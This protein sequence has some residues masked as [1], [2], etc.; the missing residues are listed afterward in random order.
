MAVIPKKF[1][2][3]SSLP[4]KKL[5][6]KIK[7]GT[8]EYTPSA[9]ILSVSRFMRM[10]KTETVYYGSCT[11]EKIQLFYHMAKKR[12]G[13][14]TGFYGKIVEDGKGSRLE[15]C[16]RKPVYAYVI[17]LLFLLVC[18]LCALGTYAAGSQQGAVVFL[19]VGLVGTVVM[20]WD[21]H[22]VFLRNYLSTFSDE[23]D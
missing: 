13:S 14:S 9:N 16:F 10:H 5:L 6:S 8:V 1:V 2:C 7:G 22:E 19:G 11:K 12:D 20:L 3:K 17:S 15:G 21:R 18:L 23:E 4:P